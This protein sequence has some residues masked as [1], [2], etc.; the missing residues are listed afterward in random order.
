MSSPSNLYAEK[1]FS[2]HPLVLW[3]LDDQADY[4]SLITEEQRDIDQ[5]WSITGGSTSLGVGVIGEP[6]PDSIT[7]VVEGSVGSE[8]LILISQDLLNLAQLNTSLGT[9]SVGTY[10]YSN[11]V[12]IKSISLGFEYTDTTSSQIVQ[13]LEKFDDPAYSSWSF[14]SGTFS[15]PNE[16][17]NFRLVIKL[18]LNAGGA[19]NSDYQVYING[20]SVGQWSE[21]FNTT[22]LGIEKQLIS[23]QIALPETYGVEA[24]AYGLS[25]KTGYYLVDQNSLVAK[26]TTIPLV[27][28]A[29]G[30]TKLLP[31]S[32]DL[33][34]VILPGQGFL[35]EAGRYKTYTVEF[36]A[37]INSNT[38]TPFKIF[39]PIASTDGIYVDGPFLTLKIG[40]NFISH[41]VGEWYRPMLI[42]LRLTKDF[43]TVLLNG[44][45]V[46]ALPFTTSELVLP[47]ILD[48]DSKNQDW[49]GFYSSED[50]TPVEIDCV[51]IYQYQVPINVA[52]RRFVY[53]QGVL[54]PEA[55]NSSYGGSSALIDYPFAKYTAN[56]SYPDFAEWQQASFD[57]LVA[58][59][60]T[61]ETPIYE[62]PEIFTNSKTLEELYESNYL[63]QDNVLPFIK[64]KPD[65]QWN[66]IGA[67]INFPRF[68]I[69]ND[70]IHAIYGIFSMPDNTST[71]I[72][73]KIYNSITNEYFII[74]KD[75]LNI[76]YYL[77][78]NGIE[79]ELYSI[80]NFSL[81]TPIA[82]GINIKN[83][84][85][86][87]GGNV[88]SFFGNQNGLKMYLGGD[89]TASNTFSG[90]IYSVGI[91]S[92][93][94][95][96][97][98]E[99]HFNLNGIINFE[100]AEQLI[101]HTASYTLLPTVMHEKFFLDIGV[102]GYWEDYMPLSYFAKYV[103]NDIGNTY[104]DLDFLQFNVGYP[105]PSKLIE[106][107]IIEESW[108]Y[109]D[110]YTSYANPTQ[111][112][113]SILDNSLYSGFN[114]YEDLSQ[115]SNKYYE[116]DTSNAI[117]K[118][119]ITFQYIIDGA[120]AL[121]NS[122]TIVENVKED[123]IIDIDEHPLWMETKFEVLDNT[124]IYP[125]KSIDFNNLAIVYHVEV[126]S[127][128]V[129]TKPLKLKTL[130]LSSQALNSNSFNPVGTRFGIDIF[131]Y[132]KSGIYYDYKSKNPFSIYKGSTPYLYMTRN[133]GIEIRGNFDPSI[134]R[135]INIPINKEIS[136]NYRI[137]A[138][139]IWHR[140]DGNNFFAT[141]T[142]FFEINLGAGR[143]INFYTVAVDQSG[144]RAK[145]YAID[146]D[147]GESFNG[148]SYY[149]NGNIVREPVLTIKEWAVLGIGFAN[150]LQFDLVIGSINL[151]GPGVFNNISYYQAN[152]L[153]QIQSKV[154]RPWLD[155][156]TDGELDIIWQYWKDS[157]SWNGML[158]VSSSDQYGVNPT[159][160]YKTYIGTNKII[161][162]DQS[163]LTFLP[164]K[165][166]VYKDS[167]WSSTV[168]T[169]A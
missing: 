8:E 120:N 69:L 94:N 146:S 71:E 99:N 79:E 131:P 157:F 162:D 68:N 164:D 93:L 19:T 163:G 121:P 84:I 135:G 75:N 149:L 18:E 41:F 167:E 104:Y 143:F 44:E 2:E 16:S 86:N 139:Q 158:V 5:Y 95:S 161:I 4:I 74:K 28:G 137:S 70:E 132:K 122:F 13:K 168:I 46:I 23:N 110:L 101:E 65:S 6:F 103:Q 20:I 7:T 108:T 42:H 83:L 124:L 15:V 57:N 17:A 34:S 55:I 96:S 114:D 73:F 91:C 111:K 123:K 37:R 63:I 78:S 11:S 45:Q 144:L 107:E 116:Y 38:Q 31:N 152:D 127:R 87:F 32:N 129:T 12:Y 22:S 82:V 113:Y 52:K 169:P 30:I 97:L 60:N 25:E 24:K 72:L 160:I 133:S 119:Y 59:K 106:K 165:V 43:A 136:S 145:V 53:G 58:Y 118:T 159:D 76:G 9:L 102:Y 134:D 142:Q 148:I 10:F 130:S 141:P 56:Y 39:G 90:K 50:V 80:D 153:Q 105:S 98:I 40:K 92:E 66:S 154:T 27:F 151:N 85:D 51:A 26:N 35:N 150:A 115:K 48:E 100:D 156:K 125:S 14:I 3:A 62:L 67:Y 140:Y 54:S 89:E 21:E 155:V 36:W 88:A 1:I 138:I 126:N 61:L 147:T 33:P 112:P 47:G 109:E 81:N 128:N 166:K 49:I 64:L 29:S 117:V 77:S